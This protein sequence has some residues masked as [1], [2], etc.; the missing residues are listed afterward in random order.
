MVIKNAEIYKYGGKKN[1]EFY[2][3]QSGSVWLF[4]KTD[5]VRAVGSGENS[6]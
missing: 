3:S 6:R 2:N 1:K 5:D 4:I